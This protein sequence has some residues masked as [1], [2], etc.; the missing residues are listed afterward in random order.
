MVLGKLFL[1]DGFF[2]HA[3]PL[4]NRID[5]EVERVLGV[6]GSQHRDSPEASVLAHLSANL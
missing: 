5:A 1:W 2:T 6:L 4:P 3:Q